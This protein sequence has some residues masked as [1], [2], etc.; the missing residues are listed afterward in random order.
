MKEKAGLPAKENLRAIFNGSSPHDNTAAEGRSTNEYCD[1]RPDLNKPWASIVVILWTLSILLSASCR[2]YMAKWDLSKAYMQLHHQRTQ[3]WRQVLYW[4]WYAG[5]VKHGGWFRDTV[6]E[7]GARQLGW[8]FHRAVTTLIVKFVLGRLVRDWLPHVKCPKLRAWQAARKAAGFTPGLQCLGAAFFGFLDDFMLF[9]MSDQRE[10]IDRAYGVVWDC[11]RFLGFKINETKHEAEGKPAQ[12]GEALGHGLSFERLTRFVT[13]HKRS[14]VRDYLVPFST[15]PTWARFQLEEVVGLLQSLQGSVNTIWW[16][17]PLYRLLRQL[18]TTG[19]TY[20]EAKEYDTTD[21]V[22]ATPRAKRVV[23]VVLKTLDDERS[24]LA[25]PFRWPVPSVELV[26]MV[27]IGDASLLGGLAGVMLDNTGVLS[28]FSYWWPDWHRQ[29]PRIP[30]AALEALTV[31]LMAAKWG[32]LFTG[33]RVVFRCDNENT[34]YGFNKLWSDSPGMALVIDLWISMLAHY[35]FEAL[36]YYV[37]SERNIYADLASREHPDVVH[38]LMMELA[39][40]DVA[41]NKVQNVPFSWTVE[42]IDLDITADLH[43]LYLSGAGKRPAPKSSRT[44]SAPNKRP[45]LPQ[46]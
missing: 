17:A 19:R 8:A 33:K 6:C 39:S 15:T 1:E 38:P 36:L 40:T 42:E 16:L 43:A 27:P 29:D 2:M 35:R 3:T 30:I 28:Y 44:Q 45:R 9:V 31:C 23:A 5:G 20:D 7:W 26:A 37:K 14:R 12:L 10:D 25:V 4:V 22:R 18:G 13:P 34:V 46:G 21:Y 41:V 11:L 32:H 24:L